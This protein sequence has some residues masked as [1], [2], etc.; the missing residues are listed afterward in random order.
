M[1]PIQAANVVFT[2]WDL[3]SRATAGEPGGPQQTA[4]GLPPEQKRPERDA[5]ERDYVAIQERTDRLVLVT[6]AMWTLV[7]EKMG[8]THADLVKRMADLDASDGT[9]DGRVTA[10]PVKC[11]C[12]AMVCRKFNRCLFCGKVYEPGST[13]DEL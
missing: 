12:G 5:F 7:S 1:D 3:M 11:S 10:P 4:G 2:I 13:F 8:V 9:V 6:Q